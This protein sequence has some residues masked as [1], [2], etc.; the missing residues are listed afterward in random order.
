MALATETDRLGRSHPPAARPAA[1]DGAGALAAPLPLADTAAPRPLKSVARF[2]GTWSR[3]RV[4][5]RL[6]QAL[7]QVPAQAGPLNSS[8][9]VRRTLLAMRELSPAY[10]DAF[11]AHVDTLQALEQAT[12]LADAPPTAPGGSAPAPEA[13]RRAPARA[14]RAP[15]TR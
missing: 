6:R 12:G 4:E 1:G 3:L 11:M 10:L 5:E 7:A 15:R 13:R 14:P 9:L 2:N 8:Q